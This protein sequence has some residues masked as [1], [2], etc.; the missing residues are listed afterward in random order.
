[1]YKICVKIIIAYN[2]IKVYDAGIA[3]ELI[4]NFSGLICGSP[5]EL[6]S[7]M[8]VLKLKKKKRLL[9]NSIFLYVS[10]FHKSEISVQPFNVSYYK[11]ELRVSISCL[12]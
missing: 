9:S 7:T 1:M 5:C 4:N 12:L 3:F 10:R 11:S 2:D 6:P 8:Y